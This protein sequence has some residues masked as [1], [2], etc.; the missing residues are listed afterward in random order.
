MPGYLGLRHAITRDHGE[1]T[2]LQWDHES[3]VTVTSGATEALAATFLGILEPGDEVILIDPAYDAYAA[4]V[5]LACA[6]AVRIA[7]D[8]PGFRITTELLSGAITQ[9]TRMIVINTPWNPTGRVLD[10]QELEAIAALCMEHDLLCV[11]DEVYERLVFDGR[12]RS[13]ASITG[14]RDRTITI[15]SLGKTYSCTGWKIGWACASG[16]LTDA[17]RAAHQF[18]VFSVPEPLQHAAEMAMTRFRDAWDQDLLD[19]YSTRRDMLMSGLESAGLDPIMPQGTYFIMAGFSRL[20][21][22][23][24]VAFCNRLLDEA[25]VA[26]IPTSVFTQEGSRCRDL[27]RFAFC[28]PDAEI[29]TA[30]ERM[31]ALG[32]ATDQTR[33]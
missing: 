10:D 7:P 6:K 18:L 14:M 9:H 33:R 11:S 19:R 3:E 5:A 27:V 31:Q 20:G 28:K 24:D 21:D 29:G 23:D 1:R 15:S 22:A 26:A 25:N 30:V 13:I 17:I 8:P 12:H 4:G 16:G 32:P 2:G